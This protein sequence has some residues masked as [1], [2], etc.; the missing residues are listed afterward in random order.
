MTFGPAEDKVPTQLGEIRVVIFAN[1]GGNPAQGI[2]GAVEILDDNGDFF[3]RRTFKNL[4]PHLTQAQKD[5]LQVFMVA[6]RA[7][8]NEQILGIVPPPPDP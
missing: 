8:A 4:A 5:G 7:K 6:L 2:K 3:E 1:P